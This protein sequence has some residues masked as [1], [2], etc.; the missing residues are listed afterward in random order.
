VKLVRAGALLLA[1]ALLGGCA[2]L[3][4][5]IANLPAH[6][7]P[8]TRLPAAQ[9]G[10]HPRQR[11][12]VFLPGG[13][14]TTPR[15]VVVFFHGGSWSRGEPEDY[16]FVGHAL[17]R[18]GYR[19]YPEARFPEFVED[20]AAAVA[21]SHAHAA[22]WCG[23]PGRLFVAG[24]SAGAH[25]AMLVALDQRRLAAAGA[26]GVIRGA[27]GLSGPYDFLPLDSRLLRAIFGAAEPL[28]DTQ[29]IRFASAASPPVLLVQ[30]RAD[31]V[32]RPGNSERLAAALA[33]NGSA[34]TLRLYDDLGHGD[35][36]A[37][38]S[39]LRDGL[40]PVLGE[41]RSFIESA[42][43]ASVQLACAERD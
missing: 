2:A 17:A 13:A 22:D 7:G 30:G 25:I 31:T 8:E 16:R 24:H 26:P 18:A 12:E 42:G 37:A 36:L 38:F 21:W 5:G 27:I 33:A 14:A 34:V 6:F 4:L 20:A 15:P 23:D 32:V 39:P 10:S 9:Y 41:I 3:T 35:T 19:L 29:P 28:S 43:G 11:L 40:A 1:L